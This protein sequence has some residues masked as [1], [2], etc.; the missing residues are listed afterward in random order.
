MA[1][2]KTQTKELF[3]SKPIAY[4]LATMAVP[5]VISQLITLFCN[6]CCVS[7]F[8]HDTFHAGDRQ[9]EAVFLSGD[10]PSAVSK[11]SNCDFA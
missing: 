10:Y 8:S 5:T 1:K 6:A 9:G 3:E 2:E 11:Y 7:E 4:A